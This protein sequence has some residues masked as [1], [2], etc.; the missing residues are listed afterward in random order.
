MSLIKRLGEAGTCDPAWRET[1]AKKP[2]KSM[3]E[4]LFFRFWATK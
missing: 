4:V 2:I 3:Y 1:I